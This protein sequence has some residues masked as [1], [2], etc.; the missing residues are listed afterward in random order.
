M[1]TEESLRD[2]K[3]VLKDLRGII[4]TLNLENADMDNRLIYLKVGKMFKEGTDNLTLD[5]KHGQ[6]DKLKLWAKLNL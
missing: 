2:N 5:N 6:A 1:A 3:P 4:E